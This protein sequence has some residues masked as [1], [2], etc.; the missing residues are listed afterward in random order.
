MEKLS[1][2]CPF[3]SFLSKTTHA[4]FSGN[5]SHQFLFIL[6]KQARR[7]GGE[8]EFSN[9]RGSWLMRKYLAKCSSRFG[10]QVFLLV[11]LDL[12]SETKV[13]LFGAALLGSWKLLA[14]QVIV[15]DLVL[16]HAEVAVDWK[17]AQNPIASFFTQNKFGW[18]CWTK[19]IFG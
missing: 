14:V 15:T 6:R 11:C 4:S 7:G 10:C 2:F 8:M 12:S 5:V 17:V 1:C 3:H 9:I 13:Y 19:L 18:Y 16:M